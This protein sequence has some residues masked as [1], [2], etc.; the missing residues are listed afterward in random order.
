MNLGPVRRWKEGNVLFAENDFIKMA[1]AVT[2][3]PEKIGTL[4]WYGKGQNA[5]CVEFISESVSHAWSI[6]S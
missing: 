1:Y 6:T 4:G 2:K 5:I 3:V